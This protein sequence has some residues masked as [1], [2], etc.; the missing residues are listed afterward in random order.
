M[1][2]S[3]SFWKG[4]GGLLG[5][6]L[7]VFIMHYFSP[8]TFFHDGLVYVVCSGEKVSILSGVL[9]RLDRDAPFYGRKVS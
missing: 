6:L 1:Q 3:S 8:T 2:N 9:A 5:V 7:P 4:G